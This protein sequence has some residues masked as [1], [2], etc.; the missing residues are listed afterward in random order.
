MS[1]SGHIRYLPAKYQN[2][3]ISMEE[4]NNLREP[5]ITVKVSELIKKFKT[6]QDIYDFC[7]EQSKYI[8]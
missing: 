7:R 6:K 1:T 5:T 8:V 3:Y 2:N 4:Q